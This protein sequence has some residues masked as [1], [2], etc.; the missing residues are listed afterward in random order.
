MYVCISMCVCICM[1]A[2]VC[3]ESQARI[4]STGFGLKSSR[5]KLNNKDPTF[6]NPV[7]SKLKNKDLTLMIQAGFNNSK[8]LAHKKSYD[9]KILNLCIK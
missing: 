7:R 2:Y 8:L 9:L 4:K 1:Y 5:S 3:V 6:S